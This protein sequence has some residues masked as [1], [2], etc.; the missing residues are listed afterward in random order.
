MIEGLNETTGQMEWIRYGKEAGL[1]KIEEL[2]VKEKLE[3]F[4]Y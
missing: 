3:K 2:V 4:I 1:Q